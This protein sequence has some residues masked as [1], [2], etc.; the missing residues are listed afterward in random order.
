MDKDQNNPRTKFLQLV[1]LAK[2]T[3]DY[4]KEEKDAKLKEER[5]DAIN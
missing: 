5:L 4:K 1:E 3:Y 2:K